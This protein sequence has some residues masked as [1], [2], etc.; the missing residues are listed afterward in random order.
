LVGLCALC[1]I[2]IVGHAAAMAPSTRVRRA[3]IVRG[4]AAGGRAAK[5]R[6]PLCAAFVDGGVNTN[7]CPPLF[8]KIV[9]EAGCASA[10]GVLG[11]N[12]YGSV[13][14][15]DFPSGCYIHNAFGGRP[16]FN[17]H[18]TGAPRSDAQPLCAGKP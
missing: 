14:Y 4:C 10:A 13:T 9:S 17:A 12:Y 18:P 11:R 16:G 7:A 15:A 2:A 1:D 3:R 8:S 5:L 6:A